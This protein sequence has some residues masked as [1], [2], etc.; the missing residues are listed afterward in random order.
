MSQE[1]DPSSM[2]GVPLPAGIHP[3]PPPFEAGFQPETLPKISVPDLPPDALGLSAEAL[4]NVPTL[5]EL[6]EQEA[7]PAPLEMP[8]PLDHQ[9]ADTESVALEA[10]S[11][12]PEATEAAPEPI[13]DTPSHADTWGEELQAR[14]GKLNDDIEVLNARLDRLEERNKTKV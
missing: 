3:E 7:H 10:E 6:V 1:H 9:P 2:D 14:M 5:T 13:Q 4:A 11:T 8:E 12:E